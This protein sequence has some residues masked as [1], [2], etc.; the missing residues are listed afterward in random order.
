MR[1]NDGVFVPSVYTNLFAHKQS[2][3]WESVAFSKLYSYT[4]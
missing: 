1:K 3:K 2:S 4:P